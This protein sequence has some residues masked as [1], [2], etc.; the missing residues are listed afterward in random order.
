MVPVTMKHISTSAVDCGCRSVTIL[1]VKAVSG[2]KIRS[3][4]SGDGSY[5]IIIEYTVTTVCENSYRLP[6]PGLQFEHS[7]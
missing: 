1:P 2:L 3:H 5:I 6:F 4:T 7:R